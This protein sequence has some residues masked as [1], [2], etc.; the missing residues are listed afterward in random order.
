M[1]GTRKNF[2]VFQNVLYRQSFGVRQMQ[3]L[4]KDE[5][6]LLHDIGGS[7]Y[8]VHHMESQRVSPAEGKALP[9]YQQVEPEREKTCLSIA[10]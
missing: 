2:R 1:F 3:I 6:G 4:C 5:R 7:M 9:F 10:C 8:G